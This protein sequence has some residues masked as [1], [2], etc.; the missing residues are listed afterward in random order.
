VRRPARS[1]FTLVEVLVAIAIAGLAITVLAAGY[2]NV[3][4]GYRAV[5]DTSDIAPDIAFC[6]YQVLRATNLEEAVKPGDTT[7]A[8]GEPLRWEA[9]VEP[10]EMPDLFRVTLKIELGRPRPDEPVKVEQ[11]FWVRQPAWSKADESGKLRDEFR[12]RIEDGRKAR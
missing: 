8:N 2:V 9:A 7:R 12:K 1:A 11:E 3:L 5:E 10:T 6:R 4:L